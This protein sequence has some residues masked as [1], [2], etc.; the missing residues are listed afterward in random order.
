MEM[1]PFPTTR[2]AARSSQKIN[3]YQ[4]GYLIL[5]VTPISIN[6]HVLKLAK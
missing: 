6:V 5:S 3:G 2:V 1:L 4:G